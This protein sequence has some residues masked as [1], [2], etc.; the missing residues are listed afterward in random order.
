M[1]IYADGTVGV[2]YSVDADP[3]LVR[4]AVPLFGTTFTNLIVVNENGIP[5]VSAESG[6][7]STV[8]ALG[9]TSLT[10]TYSTPDLTSKV[11]ILWTINATS[12]VNLLVLLP[13]G[14]TVVSMSQL[15]LDIRAVNERTQITLPPGSDSISYV[16]ST[17][18]T[19]EHAQTVIQDAEATINTVK[20]KGVITA[21]ADTLLA[22]AKT[23][24]NAGAYTTAE[25]LATQAKTSALDTDLLAQT[26]ASAIQ[27]A[28]NAIQ[29][30]KNEGRTSTIT[31]AEGY[32]ANAQNYQATGDYA[33]AKT[34]ADQA[35]DSAI[36]SKS[37]MDNTLLIVGGAV[38]LLVAVAGVILYMR[39][40][41][42]APTP[43]LPQPK[44]GEEGKVNLEAIFQKNPDLRVDD[45]EV[46]RFL[47]ERNGEAFANEIRDRFDIPR[48]SAWRMIRRLI[49]MG[50]VEERKIGGQSLISV[51]KKYR[52]AQG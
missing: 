8:D 38:V 36:T 33:K 18:G 39:R 26:A 27:K 20:A 4:V 37:P 10:F 24:L 43:P 16:I 23:A 32:L 47:A 31:T 40:R 2:V 45:K 12:P 11:G 50:I 51:V 29:A 44:K 34:N 13:A 14:S 49:T 19:P 35:Y 6:S 42:E 46:C 7:T 15:P 5:L 9:A 30:A 22:Q 17:V 25:Q 21:D 28:T 48:T 1:T 52:E 41:Q 3:T